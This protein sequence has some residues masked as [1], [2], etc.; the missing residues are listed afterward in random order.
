[1]AGYRLCSAGKIMIGYLFWLLGI[2]VCV[3]GFVWIIAY[4]Y[5]APRLMFVPPKTTI[6]GK[7]EADYTYLTH[8]NGQMI[9]TLWIGKH[10]QSHWVLLYQHGNAELLQE[11]TSRLEELHAIIGIPVF[12]Y[13]YRGYGL[14]DGKSS[15]KHLYEDGQLVWQYLTEQGY[16]PQQII[17]YGRSLGTSNA[18][19]LSQQYNPVA[20][21]ILEVPMWDAFRIYADYFWTWRSHLENGRRIKH[22][23]SPTLILYAQ[24][25]ELIA[26]WHSRKLY[27]ASPARIK[28]RIGFAVSH[29]S[30]PTT[31]QYSKVLKDFLSP[32]LAKV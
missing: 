30:I 15:I 19:L 16:T 22:I 12:A 1:M 2:S 27:D 31:P 7:K 23:T 32:V 5:L 13:E 18:T 9:Q 8:P 10:Q 24:Q 25:D 3:Y 21:T 4:Y 6:S 20:A 17:I 14:S 28:Q 26:A 11:I 29:G